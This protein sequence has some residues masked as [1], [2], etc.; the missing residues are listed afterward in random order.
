MVEYNGETM[1]VKEANEKTG[2][3]I[4]TIYNRIMRKKN[5]LDGRKGVAA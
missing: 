2:I 1:T 5:I 3:P 4:S